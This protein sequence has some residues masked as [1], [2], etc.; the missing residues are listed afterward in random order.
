ME[1][2]MKRENLQKITELRHF[3]HAHPEL[4]M[5]ENGTRK[6][7][8]RFL[9]R[10]TALEVV[11]RGSWLYAVKRGNRLPEEGIAF[12]ADMDAL[13]IPETIHLPYGSLCG[14]VSHKCGHDG[15][16]AALCGL[17][18]ELDAAET[19]RTVHLL[20]QP[21][22]EIGAGAQVCA[23]LIGEKNIREIYAFHNLSGYEEGSLVY[24]RGLTQPASEG[25]TVR[26]IGSASHASAP[27]EGVNP[28]FALSELALYA[29]EMLDRPHKGMVLCTVVGIRAGTGD[30]GVSAG[31]GEIRFTLRAEFEDE[32]ASL[33]KALTARAVKLAC[34]CGAKMEYTVSDRFPETRND[35][36]CLDRVIR[37]AERLGVPAVPMDKLWRAS[38][39]FGHYTKLCPGAMFYIGAGVDHPPL[40]TEGYDFNDRILPAAVD[41]MT[42]LAVE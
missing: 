14:G 39:D 28:S 27:E 35:D 37:C 2:M 18:L 23:P 15:H 21:G 8:R 22:E 32:M 33:E 29:R 19:A 36:G 20:F 3:L 7:I 34:S 5:E 13:P 9:E 4:S 11:D 42:A 24:R 1:R 41:I 38:E 6:A 17:A 12:R 26:F 25:L 31:E 30:F 40:H 10:S 16:C